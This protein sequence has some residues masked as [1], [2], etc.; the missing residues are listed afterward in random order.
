[1]F[2]AGAGT[3]KRMTQFT[4]FFKLCWLCGLIKGIYHPDLEWPTNPLSDRFFQPAHLTLDV[5]VP[6]LLAFYANGNDVDTVLVDGKVLMQ[7]RKVKSV[8][9]KAVVEMAREEAA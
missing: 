1:M 3:W 7:D 2:T 5:S 4:V 8:D 9:E 6:R